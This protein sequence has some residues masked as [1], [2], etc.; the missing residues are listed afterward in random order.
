MSVRPLAAT[1]ERYSDKGQ[2]GEGGMGEVRLMR[3]ERIG[4][5]VALKLIRGKSNEGVVERFLRE[6]RVQAQLEHPAV[7]PV[8]DL[9]LTPDGRTFFTMKRV[10]GRSLDTNIELLSGD[11]VVV[12]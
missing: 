11:I 8:Y 4:R 6:A 5:D 12:P 10:R 2:L 9:G 3:D 7:V 1:G